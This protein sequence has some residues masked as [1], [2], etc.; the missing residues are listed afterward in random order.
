MKF[1]KSSSTS[2][3]DY[4]DQISN[5]NL[6]TE[7]DMEVP[8]G[9][10]KEFLIGARILNDSNMPSETSRY[11]YIHFMDDIEHPC[12]CMRGMKSGIL[13]IDASGNTAIL[14]NDYNSLQTFSRFIF[15]NAILELHT[16]EWLKHRN[17]SN[18]S[19]TFCNIL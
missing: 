13:Q 5:T 6:T 10:G 16:N 1:W 7:C 18:E 12:A 8:S 3:Y 14:D 15:E 9:F 11:Y 2:I 4:I 17:Q 19:Y